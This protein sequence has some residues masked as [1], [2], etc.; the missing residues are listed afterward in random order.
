LLKIRINGRKFGLGRVDHKFYAD[1]K[2]SI[3]LQYV[4]TRDNR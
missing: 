3:K 2:R 1:T 4:E